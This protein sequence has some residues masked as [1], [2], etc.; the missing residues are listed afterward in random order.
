MPAMLQSMGREEWDM[1]DCLSNNKFLAWLNYSKI[2]QD[3]QKVKSEKEREKEERERTL[4]LEVDIQLI[5]L[6]GLDMGNT[7]ENGAKVLY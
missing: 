2:R 6:D 5:E 3:F 4:K 7:R 1:T